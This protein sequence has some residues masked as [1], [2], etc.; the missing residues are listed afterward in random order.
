M[1]VLVDHAVERAQGRIGWSGV[2]ILP[3]ETDASDSRA[4]VARGITAELIGLLKPL[5]TVTVRASGGIERGRGA[6]L[7]TVRLKLR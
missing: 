6:G 7:R 3:F 1:P 2:L 5:A 4:F